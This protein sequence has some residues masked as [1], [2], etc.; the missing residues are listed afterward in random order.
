MELKDSSQIIHNLNIL[1]YRI[2][3]M[4]LKELPNEAEEVAVGGG[5]SIQWN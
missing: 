1:K 3:S 4:E 5:E 2:H